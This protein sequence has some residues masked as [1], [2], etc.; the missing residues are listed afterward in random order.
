MVKSCG[1]VEGMSINPGPVQW[2]SVCSSSESQ[3]HPLIAGIPIETL[4]FPVAQAVNPKVAYTH[5]EGKK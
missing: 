3:G 5:L 2:H 1:K 4:S